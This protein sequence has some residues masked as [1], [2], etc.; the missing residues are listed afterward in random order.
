MRP[1]LVLRQ[2]QK[3]KI[4]QRRIYYSVAVLFLIS[5]CFVGLQFFKS[6]TVMAVNVNTWTNNTG[7]GNW[8]DAGN[9]SRSAVPGV[10]DVA[11]FD[12]TNTSACSIN[13]NINIAGI[14]VAPGYS[15]VITQAT[16]RTITLGAS[17]FSQSAG[18]F[19]GGN[20]N[21]TITA[22]TLNLSGGSFTA[23][24]A[25]MA[26]AGNFS[27]SAN[28]FV[29]TGGTFNHNNG[30]FA[31]NAAVNSWSGVTYTFDV[32]PATRFN[33]LI[34]NAST[35]CNVPTITTASGDTV[36]CDNMITHTDG[37]IGGLFAFSGN[38]TVNS[39]ADGGNGWLIPEGS[40]SQ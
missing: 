25:T 32:L 15:G 13:N 37:Y 17:G 31:L 8:N 19:I 14:N 39:G 38:L 33:N 26:I 20:S 22:G 10:N 3:Q 16:G 27:A 2:T 24:S 28:V 9:W 11:T 34:L 29:Q 30:T 40:S 36:R 12:G 35:C 18:S 1:R 21:F 5:C 23:P 6:E 4:T 7:S